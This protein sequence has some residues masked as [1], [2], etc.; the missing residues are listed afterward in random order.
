MSGLDDIA[1]K[2]ES[3]EP[4]AHP[5]TGMAQAI[6]REI[7]TCVS[8]LVETHEPGVI[9]LK[10]MPL[11]EADLEELRALLGRG[12]VHATIEIAGPTELYET[13]YAGVW[14]VTHRNIEGVN[15]AEQIEIAQVPSIVLTHR[16]DIGAGLARLADS[17][18]T[19]G[20]VE[21]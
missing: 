10:G 21:V 2:V 19:Q 15:V 1:V 17:L 18:A 8:R 9:D 16:D 3:I 20:S 5:S 7:H 14:W 11:T 13:A 6:L 12:E 4:G